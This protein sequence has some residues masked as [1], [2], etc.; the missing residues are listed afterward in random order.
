MKKGLIKLIVSILGVH[1]VMW[2]FLE[3][4]IFDFLFFYNR[5]LFEGVVDLENDYICILIPQTQKKLFYLFTLQIFQNSHF[6]ED[7]IL[8][9]LVYHS[10]ISD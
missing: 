7:I 9:M 8:K 4:L 3:L 5:Y 10:F 6:V 1:R 2:I